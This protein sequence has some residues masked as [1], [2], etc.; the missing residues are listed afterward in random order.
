[1]R[2]RWN[3]LA[4]AACGVAVVLL[5]HLSG[6]GIRAQTAVPPTPTPFAPTAEPTRDPFSFN[7]E[8]TRQFISGTPTAPPSL[9]GVNGYASAN[10]A[11]RSG[12]GLEYPRVGFLAAGRSIDIV[13]YN[14]YNLDRA[15]SPV[16]AND[17]DMWVL[18]ASPGGVARGWMARCT[19]RITGEFNMRL[20][21][22]N[23]PPP[24]SRPPR[25]FAPAA[26]A[27]TP[28]G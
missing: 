18:V 21:L 27:A 26:D 20:M 15:C 4:Y 23:Q 11:I 9:T 5:V 10:T 13:G 1:M 22:N 2:R 7:L 19:L 16:F 3:L 6:T 12:P 8:P 28:S 24:G 17:L 25:D 14:G